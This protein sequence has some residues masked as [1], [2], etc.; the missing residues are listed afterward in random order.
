MG[1]NGLV[2]I[3]LLGALVVACTQADDERGSKGNNSGAA[4]VAD[5]AVDVFGPES[6]GTGGDSASDGAG[7]GG[8]TAVAKMLDRPCFAIA[9]DGEFLYALTRGDY[10]LLRMPASGGPAETLGTNT[11]MTALAATA[12]SV[13]AVAGGSILRFA[14]DGTQGTLV[15][16]L[17]K[18]S[19]VAILG[20]HVYWTDVDVVQKA[21]LSGG[22][23]TTVAAN[24]DTPTG[25]AVAGGRVF[26]TNRGDGTIVSAALDGTELTTLASGQAQ[27]NAIASNG[28]TVCWT[29]R[30]SPFV[31]VSLDDGELVR[32]A[33]SGGTPT[34]LAASL[35]LPSAVALD[36][37]AV[38][39]ANWGSLVASGMPK[40]NGGLYRLGT[41]DA[42]PQ[43]LAAGQDGVAALAL[44]AK[45]VYWCAEGASGAFSGDAGVTGGVYSAP[46]Q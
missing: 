37:T 31:D 12:G 21:P 8:A 27:P 41:D 24:Q 29:N 28:T 33:T 32:I 25:L 16:G 14:P 46:K 26:W 3:V 43:V 2:L 18:P 45:R 9:L 4:G 10:A 30:G 6:G 34:V 35:N 15:Q 7:G 1:R 17:K 20:D 22:A 23:V 36:A 11:K 5:S 42:V 44:G 19:A 39:W 13:V 38:Y 40:P